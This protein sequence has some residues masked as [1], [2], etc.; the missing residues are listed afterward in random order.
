MSILDYAPGSGPD[1]DR[2]GTSLFIAL[3]AFIAYWVVTPAAYQIATGHTIVASSQP[4]SAPSTAIAPH[5]LVA[6]S[7]AAPIVGLIT[8]LVGNALWRR[9]AFDTLGLTSRRL[10]L[11]MVPAGI[12]IAIVL[13]GM[14]VVELLTEK[15]WNAIHYAHPSE[16]DLLRIL[17][18]EPSRFVR[19]AIAVSAIVLA[20]VFEEFFFRGMIQRTVRQIAGNHRWIAIVIA[21][22]AFTA[23]HGALWLAPP[24]FILSLAL[25]YAY[26]R[27][28]NLWVPIAVHAAFN[29]TS[30]AMFLFFR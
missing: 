6:L 30:L 27:T 21:S 14:F 28:G 20:P 10:R 5:D 18:E 16:H 22:L 12:A 9:R 13:P 25:G 3:A 7:I 24:I 26:D 15:F 11:A 2:P 29:A 19:V 17:G 4:T 8:L 23:V 1:D